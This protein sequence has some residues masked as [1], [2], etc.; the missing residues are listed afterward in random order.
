[1]LIHVDFVKSTFDKIDIIN[2]HIYSSVRLIAIALLASLLLVPKRAFNVNFVPLIASS[3]IGK[4][5][6]CK[7]REN[8]N[9]LLR[10][11]HCKH[12][13]IL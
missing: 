13:Y 1:M 7:F 12:I 3:P 9:L 4:Q 6:S 2:I 8:F 10:E 11:H 5:I